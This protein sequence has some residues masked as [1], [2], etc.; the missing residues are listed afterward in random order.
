M[1]SFTGAGASHAGRVRE[2]NEDSA[3]LAPYLALVAD[4]VGGA[5]AGEV[6]SATAAR[7]FAEG[8]RGRRGEDPADAVHAV[9]A[10][11]GDR[12]THGVEDDPERGGMATTMTAVV[13]DGSRVVLAHVGDSRC[14]LFRDGD[15][16]RVS[17]DHTYV[18]K[19]VDDGFM[20]PEA[21]RHHPWRHVVV[22][23]LHSAADG[24]IG[25]A[26]LVDL[27]VRPGDRILL[28]SDGL[29]DLVTEHRI[30]EILHVPSPD[31]AAGRLVA[32]ALDSGG[33]DNITCVV[34]DLAE[35]APDLDDE[36]EAFGAVRDVANVIGVGDPVRDSQP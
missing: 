21:V 7:V 10:E 18:Q 32:D 28:C 25:P 1:L 34:L 6:A 15:L 14:Y 30:A 9:L 13:T 5:A 3:W 35:A 12:L 20:A 23:S 24:P 22:R 31:A 33:T 29:T 36:G 16:T 27:A 8:V 11:V 4:G 19:L 17:T 2:Q 26:D